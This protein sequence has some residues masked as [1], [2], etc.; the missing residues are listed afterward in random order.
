MVFG[1]AKTYAEKTLRTVLGDVFRHVLNRRLITFE[2]RDWV[3]PMNHEAVMANKAKKESQG[4]QSGSIPCGC[5]GSMSKSID[6]QAKGEPQAHMS[7]AFE[8]K[9]QLSSGLYR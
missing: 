7:D 8:M 4:K 9:S 3:R 5:P 6:R 1:K 2:E